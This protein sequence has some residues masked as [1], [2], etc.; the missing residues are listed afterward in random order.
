METLSIKRLKHRVLLVED[1]SESVDLVR[2]ICENVDED[3]VL[4]CVDTAERAQQVLED[5][6]Q[7]DL[8][9]SDHFLAGPMTGLDL[10]RTCKKSFSQVPFMMT[11]SLPVDEFLKLV[12]GEWDY[13]LYLHKPFYKKDCQ[14]MIDWYLNEIP[15]R[16]KRVENRVAQ[17]ISDAHDFGSLEY[18]TFVAFVLLILL[19][20]TRMV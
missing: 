5:D 10:W 14:H 15:K 9:I 1:G 3:M 4:K 18:G 11:S 12:R 17:A 20:A 19:I 13:P 2:M 8:I 6:P 16:R 7:F